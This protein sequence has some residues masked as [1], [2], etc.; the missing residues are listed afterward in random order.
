MGLG[1]GYLLSI[2]RCAVRGHLK[3]SA[4]RKICSENSS[5]GFFWTSNTKLP[6]PPLNLCIVNHT[7]RA[8]FI[9]VRR[10][11]NINFKFHLCHFSIVNAKCQAANMNIFSSI[12]SV[13]IIF[14]PLGAR[15]IAGPTAAFNALPDYLG[16]FC[17][18]RMNALY[19]RVQCNQPFLRR[20][21]SIYLYISK[22]SL[23]RLLALGQIFQK[24]ARRSLAT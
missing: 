12:H 17:A 24:K 3:I 20:K 4:D 18:S 10:L 6:C 23:R 22:N 1:L 2:Q 15:T 16:N 19:C 21:T 7:L 13:R 5:P 8:N 9:L 14:P 11:N